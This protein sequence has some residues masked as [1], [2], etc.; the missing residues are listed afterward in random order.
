VGLLQSLPEHD[1]PRL[2]DDRHVTIEKI[3]IRS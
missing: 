3:H 1:S 2:A